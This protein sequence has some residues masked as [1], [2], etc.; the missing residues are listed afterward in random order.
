MNLPITDEIVVRVLVAIV[1]ATA[2]V[3]ERQYKWQKYV[4]LIQN[5]FFVY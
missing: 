5:I 4:I 1:P 3:V 2:G